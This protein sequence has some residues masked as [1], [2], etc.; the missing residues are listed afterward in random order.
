MEMFRECGRLLKSLKWKKRSRQDATASPSFE[1][2]ATCDYDRPIPD[3]NSLPTAT[4]CCKPEDCTELVQSHANSATAAAYA[5]DGWSNLRELQAQVVRNLSSESDSGLC[6]D[7][8]DLA[9][10][11]GSEEGEGEEEEETYGSDW[12]GEWD[13]EEE[14][15]CDECVFFRCED[16]LEDWRI[17]PANLSLGKVLVN[18]GEDM[19]YR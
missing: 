7:E 10:E 2:E 9:T 13:E 17:S 14:C 5:K 19:V 8:D 4:P 11:C 18:Q 1:R 3:C 6:L 16:Q 12:E 15:G